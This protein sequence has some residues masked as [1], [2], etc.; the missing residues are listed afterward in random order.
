MTNNNSSASFASRLWNQEMMSNRR[1]FNQQNPVL[2]RYAILSSPRSGSTLLSRALYQTR[3]AGD[4]HEYLNPAA[5][6]AYQTGSGINLS[7]DA[8]L[9]EIENRRTSSNGLFGIK[10]HHFHLSRLGKTPEEKS[11][12]TINFL[13]RQDKRI[14]IRRRDKIAQSVSYYIA[15]QSGRWT[16]E[17]ERYLTDGHNL[18]VLFDPVALSRCLQRIIEDEQSFIKI[19][20][21]SNLS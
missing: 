14:L 8:Y 19:L 20:K 4:P 10:T 3:Q 21:Y 15:Q 7:I 5:I 12:V 1:D 17:H 16:T 13:K 2:L 11:R 6:Y 18:T 9:Q